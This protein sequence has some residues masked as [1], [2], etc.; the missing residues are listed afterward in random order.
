MIDL[1]FGFAVI[2]KTNFKWMI[3]F[4]MFVNVIIINIEMV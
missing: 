3:M 4:K 2:L 1:K